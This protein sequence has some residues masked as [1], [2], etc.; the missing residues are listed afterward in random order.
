MAHERSTA[1]ILAAGQGSRL[2]PLTINK[3]KALVSFAG[4]TLLDR[5][6]ETFA[7]AG[8][9]EVTVATGHCAE[10]VSK[11]GYKTVKN[12][13][14][15]NTNMV[16][17]FFHTLSQI[18]PEQDL[19]ISYGDIL[20]EKRILDQ[21]LKCDSGISVAIDLDWENLWQTRFADPLDDAETLLLNNDNDILEIGK[22]PKSICDIQGQFIGLIKVRADFIGFLEPFYRSIDRTRS[23]EG[24]S[25]DDM[26]MTAF[27]QELIDNG[28]PIKAIPFH[29]GWLEIDTLSDLECYNGM[30]ED[31]TLDQLFK[32]VN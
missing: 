13:R 32:L 26:F 12:P 11:L 27:L 23:F 8:V 3:P 2:H 31:K 1:I 6:I 5:Q 28:W 30:L 18:K 16:F 22:K 20:F 15:L 9:T 7:K 19:I 17:T 14:F 4:K 10:A 21:A 29:S 24:R 25:F